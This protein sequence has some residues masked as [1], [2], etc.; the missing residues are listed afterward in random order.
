M[1]GIHCV[2]YML[3]PILADGFDNAHMARFHGH[4]A[5]YAAVL[6]VCNTNLFAKHPSRSFYAQSLVWSLENDIMK[7]IVGK[8]ICKCNPL[9]W[10]TIN[11]RMD[12][13]LSEFS[14]RT[15]SYIG[16]ASSVERS[17]SLQRRTQTKETNLLKRETVPNIM[18][19]RGNILF[20]SR[21]N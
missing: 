5:I 3:D 21:I 16:T 15:F 6:E 8:Y 17:F 4:A 1:E 12:I 18:F 9:L 14:V 13:A 11:I 2:L 20:L 10:C 19:C 7:R